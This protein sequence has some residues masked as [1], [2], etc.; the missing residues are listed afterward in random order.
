ML[1]E[2]WICVCPKCTTPHEKYITMD[3]DGFGY[4]LKVIDC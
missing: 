1:R 2:E 3:D 4:V